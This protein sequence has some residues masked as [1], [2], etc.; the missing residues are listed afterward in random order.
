MDELVNVVVRAFKS[1]PIATS[2]HIFLTLQLCMIE[3]MKVKGSHKY[4]IPHVNK[5]RLESLDKLP[6][7]FKC[8]PALVQ[9]VQEY[10]S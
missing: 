5:E 1:F 9:Q 3:I 4:K 7:Q 2:N 6:T 8:D 10:L